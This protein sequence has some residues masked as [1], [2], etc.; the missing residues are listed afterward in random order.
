MKLGTAVVVLAISAI[1]ALSPASAAAGG[2]L[3]GVSAKNHEN[4]ADERA[5]SPDFEREMLT[6]DDRFALPGGGKKKTRAPCY[7]GPPCP[8]N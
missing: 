4:G 5:S 1:V 3:R 6:T 7:E 2:S 8:N